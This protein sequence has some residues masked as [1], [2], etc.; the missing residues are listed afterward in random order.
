MVFVKPSWNGSFQDDFCKIIFLEKPHI[1]K[2]VTALYTMT[3]LSRL[4]SFV[5]RKIL[6]V[7][8]TTRNV[9]FYDAHSKTVIWNRLRM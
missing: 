6:V 4:L 7:I 3:V 2:I 1:Y 5:Y 8:N 9:L